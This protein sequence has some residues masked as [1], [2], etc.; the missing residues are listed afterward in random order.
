MIKKYFSNLWTAAGQLKDTGNYF[1]KNATKDNLWRLI[2]IGDMAVNAVCGGDP[3]ET[4]SSRLGK[5]EDETEIFMAK[6]VDKI[7]WFD[8]DH[9]TKAILENEGSDAVFK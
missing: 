3:Q 4:I 7:M 1:S 2:V 9:C 6:V 5:R 8:K